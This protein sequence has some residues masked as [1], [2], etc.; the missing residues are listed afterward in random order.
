MN[1]KEPDYEKDAGD[2]KDYLKGKDLS[3]VE[4]VQRQKTP[5]INEEEDHFKFMQIDVDYYTSNPKNIPGKSIT[6]S[7]FA[8]FY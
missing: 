7:G 8:Q 4:N 2:D 1:N 5:N 3:R 6:S